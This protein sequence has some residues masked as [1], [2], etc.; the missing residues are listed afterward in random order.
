MGRTQHPV[1]Y[2]GQELEGL[3]EGRGVG[4]KAFWGGRGAALN[5]SSRWRQAGQTEGGAPRTP[6][7]GCRGLR[8]AA[9]PRSSAV[10]A[11]SSHSGR[12]LAG[13]V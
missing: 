9:W 3:V 12:H 5:S 13:N 2:L 6:E 1:W 7:A 10:R 4:E 11:M 8:R